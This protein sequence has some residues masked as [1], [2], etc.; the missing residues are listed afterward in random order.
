M[1]V[2][3][4]YEYKFLPYAIIAFLIYIVYISEVHKQKTK[5]LKSV[6]HTE[7]ISASASCFLSLLSIANFLLNLINTPT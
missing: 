1:N 4:Y 2:Y 3:S 5:N 6:S 7:L